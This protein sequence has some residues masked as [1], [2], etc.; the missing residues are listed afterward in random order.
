VNRLGLVASAFAICAGVG[1]ATAELLG[2]E[3]PSPYYYLLPVV[4]AILLA[5]PAYVRGPRDPLSPALVFAVIFTVYYVLRPLRVLSTGM[6]GPAKAAYDIPIAPVMDSIRVALLLASIG[7]ASFFLGYISIVRAATTSNAQRESSPWPIITRERFHLAMVVAVACVTAFLAFLLLKS[8]GL[9]AYLGQIGYRQRT[10]ANIAFLTQ[11]SVPVKAVL[12]VALLSRRAPP[13]HRVTWGVIVILGALAAIADVFS[14]GRSNLI[15]GTTLPALLIVH[16]SLRPLRARTVLIV[17]LALLAIAV[18]FRVVFRD[19]QFSGSSNHS[20][21]SLLQQSYQRP[22]DAIVGGH[23]AIAFDSLATLNGAYGRTYAR[24]LGL[25]YLDAFTFPAPRALWPGKPLGGG[26]AWF[27]S[28]YFPGYYGEDHV[29]TS[30]TLL[31][32]AEANFGIAGVLLV[33]ALL[34]IGLAYLYRR[35]VASLSAQS[36][37]VYANVA[38]YA[39]TLIRGDAYHSIPSALIATGASLFVFNYCTISS[40]AARARAADRATAAPGLRSI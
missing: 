39:F 20:R 27:T 29:E 36:I 34:G 26:N 22:I 3:P 28:T 16:Y 30:V 24:R 19:S 10:F 37:L 18:S 8:G 2:P 35:T 17:G 5:V 13:P 14:G 6:V 32:E 21:T 11:L 38:P 15:V 33:P 31:G 9:A 7:V 12:F 4:A 25:T 40:S 23:D 1:V